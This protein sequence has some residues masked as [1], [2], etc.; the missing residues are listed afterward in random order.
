MTKKI[1][2]AAAVCFFACTEIPED[3][4]N[5]FIDSD[6]QFCV[7]KQTFEKCWGKAFD[8]L[9][10][11]CYENVV[12]NKC[13]GQV[14]TPPDNPCGE[15]S[16]SSIGSSSSLNIIGNS[17]SS[18][19]GSS[20]SLNISSSSN[21]NISSSSSSNIGNSSSSEASSS[22]SLNTGGSSSSA[23]PSSSSVALSSSSSVPS[24]SATFTCTMTATTGT[25]GMAISPIPT[26]SCNGTSVI[27]GLSWTP[28]G[29]TPT[30]EGS[31]SV[32]V[33]ANSGVCSG[34]TTPC[35]SINVSAPK[36]ECDMTAT[37]V[38]LGTK[39][40]PIP[41]V[42]CSGTLV[43]SLSWT[44]A[45]LIPATFGY[46]SVRVS[47]SSGLCSGM[48]IDCGDIVVNETEIEHYGKMKK[49]FYDVRDGKKYVYVVI[50]T[51]T[52]MAENLNY[53]ATGSRCYG[54]NSGNDS[55]G[56][57]V[58]YGRLY[59]WNTAKTVCP[60][61]WHL[62]SIEEWSALSIYVRSN[63][64]CS[65]CDATK[66]K[67]ISD[68]NSNGNGMDEY[69]FSALPGGYYSD[70]SFSNVGGSS[71]W[72]SSSELYSGNSSSLIYSR[73]MSYNLENVNSYPMN[74]SSLQSVRCMKD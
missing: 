46:V 65:N 35:G 40:S 44:P 16:S 52:W 7:N 39:I 36:L 64:D 69:G 17:S 15:R 20:S 8:P 1:L 59:N 22:S 51:Q 47:A 14:Y 32:S 25:K 66:L 55:Q 13:N 9:T 38:E 63:S 18:V 54:D 42:T 24:S 67:T 28:S 58:K 4:G 73:G 41:T 37:E 29:Y 6:T 27:T 43:T 33:T 19:V 49:Q 11:F 30:T 62:P 12:Y 72:W 68:W 61:G 56:N 26:A 57:C 31:V 74:R 34:M 50:G 3:C 23:T 48:T 71:F 21:Q 10:E 53:N 60:E 2:L 70:G 45:N 5:Q